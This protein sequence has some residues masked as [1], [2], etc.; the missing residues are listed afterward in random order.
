MGFN[1]GFKGLNQSATAVVELLMMDM[2][3]P[4]TCWAV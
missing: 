3:T 1:A 2:G 4:E